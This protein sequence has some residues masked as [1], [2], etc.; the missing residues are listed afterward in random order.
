M[1]DPSSRQRERPTSTNPL[2]SDNNK[3]LLLS[4]RWVLYSKTDS[5][6]LTVGRNVRLRLSLKDPSSEKTFVCA[7]VTLIFG[8]YK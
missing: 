6:Q 3:N 4:L 7:V 5:G 1:I 8:V 2:L